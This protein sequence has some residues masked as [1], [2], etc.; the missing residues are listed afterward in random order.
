MPSHV[1]NATTK[2]TA[3]KKRSSSDNVEKAPKRSKKEDADSEVDDAASDASASEAEQEEV[4]LWKLNCAFY[5]IMDF[6]CKDCRA[7]DRSNQDKLIR[8]HDNG[9]TS[10]RRTFCESCR[11]GNIM[12]NNVFWSRFQADPE[13]KKEYAARRKSK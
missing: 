8:Q 9:L 6:Q 11:D 5:G 2:S 10:V 12:M 13:K 4:A 3:A 7:R 1:S